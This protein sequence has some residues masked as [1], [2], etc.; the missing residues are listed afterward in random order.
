MAKGQTPVKAWADGR[1]SPAALAVSPAL[2]GCLPQQLAAGQRA[3]LDMQMR[4][5]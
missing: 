1:P 3:A 4:I 5:E 2:P